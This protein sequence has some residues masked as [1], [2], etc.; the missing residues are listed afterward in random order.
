VYVIT[1]TF[2]INGSA[3]VCGGG[4]AVFSGS[5]MTSC[6]QDGAGD[7]VTFYLSGNNASVFVNGTSNTQMYAPNSG[8][9][10]GLLFY[11]DPTDTHAATINGTDQSL[12]QGAI[13]MPSADLTFGGTSNFNNGAAYTVVVTYQFD[14]AGNTYVNLASNLNGLANGGGPLAGTVTWAHLVE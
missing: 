5:T 7:G 8:T 11:Q 4:V 1:G 3:N 2:K 14:V 12:F 13:Y 9:Y 6:T 10:E